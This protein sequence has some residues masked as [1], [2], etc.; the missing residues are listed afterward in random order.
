MLHLSN[1]KED[2]K[3][4]GIF[5]MHYDQNISYTNKAFCNMTHKAVQTDRLTGGFAV[6]VSIFVQGTH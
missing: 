4:H 5:K 2:D 3:V 6:E 1:S